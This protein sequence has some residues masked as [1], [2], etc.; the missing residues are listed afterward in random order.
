MFANW[1]SLQDV[2]RM[3][4]PRSKARIKAAISARLITSNEICHITTDTPEN[5]IS[6]CI[7]HPQVATADAYIDLAHRRPSM[8]LQAVR[9]CIIADYQTVYQ[10]LDPGYEPVL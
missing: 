9:A 8:K 4:S 10:E 7:W 5:E 3:G 2:P 6:Y 1:C